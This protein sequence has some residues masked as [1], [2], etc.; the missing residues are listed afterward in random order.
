MEMK[1]TFE[2]FD[3]DIKQL[4]K[5]TVPEV[6]TL[7]NQLSKYL[8]GYKGAIYNPD[9]GIKA[10]IFA[11]SGHGTKENLVLA[12][13]GEPLFLKDIVE[14]L[15]VPNSIRDTCNKIPK[16]FFIDA[17][18]GKRD[19]EIKAKG[20]L[21]VNDVEGNFRIEYAT[22]QDHIAFA[23]GDESV[24]MPVLARQLRQSND[25]YQNVIATVNCKV[26]RQ[27]SQWPQVQ[28]QLIC[29][30]LTLYYKRKQTLG[31]RQMI[32]WHVLYLE[33]IQMEYPCMNH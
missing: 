31:Y 33:M 18:R 29:G 17:C 14:P 24:W 12:N 5:A 11:F 7:V 25:T 2:Q 23:D 26:Y 8:K 27:L 28:G 22:I 3:Y 15:V 30:P 6:T 13:D 9:D 19:I 10:I 16:L 20:E 4:K 21:D 32:K 1:M